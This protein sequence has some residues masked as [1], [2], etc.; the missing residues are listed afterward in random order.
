MYL[1]TLEEVSK[2]EG[3]LEAI[4]MKKQNNIIKIAGFILIT[5]CF[6]S[7]L[8]AI[9]VDNM[10]QYYFSATIIGFSSLGARQYYCRIHN[11]LNKKCDPYKAEGAYTYMYL[12]Y[13]D[14]KQ[15]KNK[16]NKYNSLGYPTLIA[17]SIMLQGDFERAFSIL[18]QM[19]LAELNKTHK[20]WVCNYHDIM[21]MYYCFKKDIG[22]LLE[23]RQ[24]LYQFSKTPGLRKRYQRMMEREI[25]Y[26]NLFLSLQKEDY[27]VYHDL[28]Q[29]A[30]WNRGSV[31]QKV[32]YRWI[33][34]KVHRMQGNIEAAKADCQYILEHGN[35]LYYVDLA[36]Q[37]L[38]DIA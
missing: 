11:I 16:Y 21:R 31:I 1:K 20:I 37:M 3:G 25:D 23:M 29:R 12:A 30:N 7:M 2:S 18:N 6:F 4:K 36:K 13:I 32:S 19:D 9:R 35:R 15:Y 34:A 22:V 38:E 27:S 14:K 17:R 33:D 24:Y 26:I 5:I 28:S 8:N 10:F